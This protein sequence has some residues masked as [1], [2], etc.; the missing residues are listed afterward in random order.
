MPV[1]GGGGFAFVGA[2]DL[3]LDLCVSLEAMKGV[4]GW[5]W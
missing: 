5:Q 1:P 3:V 4:M 2:E